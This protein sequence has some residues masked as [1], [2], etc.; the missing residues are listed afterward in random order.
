MAG[1]NS[2]TTLNGLFK[3]VYA[4]K[5][6]D[7]I[8]DYAILQKRIDF[9]SAEKETGAYYAQP[10]VLSAE[11]GFTYNGSAGSTNSSLLD[12]VA[13]QMKE[14]QVYGS[15]LILRSR[16][17]YMALSRAASA[18]ARAFKRASSF[19]VE[20]M[21]NSMRKRLEI[22]MLYGQ[23][24]IGTLNATATDTGSSTATLVISEATWAGGIW[25]GSEGCKLDLMDSTIANKLNTADIVVTAVDSDTRTLTVTCDNTVSGY[26]SGSILFFKGAATAGGT[27]AYSEM[28]G[29]SAIIGNSGTLFNISAATYSLWKGTTVSSVGQISFAKIQD[30]IGRAANK[31]LMEKVL[32]LVSPKA[33]SV[34]N[35]D[36]AALRMFDSSFS[37]KKAENGAESLMFHGVTGPMEVVAHPLVKD[38]DAFIVPPDSLMR[39]GSLDLSFGV[40]G[41]DEQFFTL[42]V[43]SN[44][45]ELQCLADQAIFL[46][47]PAHAV[48]MTGITYS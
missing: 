25:A 1:E 44:A 5:L 33:W 36:Q 3:T 24:G 26:V 30:A 21:N 16:L 4:D 39:V 27:P 20:D 8:P 38:G 43:G 9:V 46:E 17:N 34:L 47:K 48:K 15:E 2:V 28:A 7:L 6:I 11:S 45:V 14:A 18:G 22:A 13:G 23:S 41:F 40:P 37:A 29:L 10:V 32:V 35:A 12:A 19:K 31:G 42:V